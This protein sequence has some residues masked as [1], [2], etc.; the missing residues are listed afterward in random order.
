[1]SRYRVCDRCGSQIGKTG[2]IAIQS[3]HLQID[4]DLCEACA[5]E[6]VEWVK[7]PLQPRGKGSA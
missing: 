3:Y 6:L 4:V 7:S 5:H 2:W 1:M